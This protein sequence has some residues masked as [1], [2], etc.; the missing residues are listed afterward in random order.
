MGRAQHLLDLAAWAARWLPM[1]LKRTLY[2]FP[3]LAGAIRRGLNRLAPAGLT[4]VEVAAGDLASWL[5]WLDLQSEKDYWLGTYEPELQQ[6]LADLVQPGMVAYD[7]GANIGYISLLLAR[8][9]GEE[10]KVYAFEAL[11]ANQER[12]RL[13]LALNT[14]GE[15]V[16]LVPAAV[17][18]MER[19]VRFLVGPSGGMGKVD[20]SAG[21]QE[22]A[23]AEALEIDGLSLDVFVYDR[24]NPPPQVVKMDIEGGEVLALPGMVRLLDK[25]RP[26]LLLELHGPEAAQCAWEALTSRGYRLCRMAPGYPPVRT[27][28]ELDWKAYVVAL[29]A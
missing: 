3:P 12:L 28:N 20:G 23:Y 14:L 13:N 5:L 15:R 10:G 6:A 19:P 26:I 16:C 7:V 21:R 9:V 22:V 27:Q 2:R 17:V 1:P 25:A 11:P 18:E 24:G 29:P 8:R 4:Q